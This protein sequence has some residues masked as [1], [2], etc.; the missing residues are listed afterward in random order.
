MLF[1]FSDEHGE[2]RR[3]VRSF[4]EK[5]S[6]ENRVRELMASERGYDPATWSRMAEELG[7]V[8]LIVSEQ[9]G[10][11]EFGMVELAIVAEEIRAER[12][13]SQAGGR[14]SHRDP[15]VFGGSEPVGTL[16]DYHDGR[17]RR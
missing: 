9:H 17:P 4:L 10:G 1:E 2:L 12:D 11:A 7:L 5:E 13:P 8:G 16:G 6:D 15:G 14:R 3:T